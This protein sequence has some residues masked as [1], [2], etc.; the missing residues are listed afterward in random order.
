MKR[1]LQFLFLILLL[2]FTFLAKAEE[3]YTFDPMHSYVLYHINHF[4]F[5]NP[6]GKWMFNGTVSLDKNKPQNSKVNIV[7]KTADIVTGIP[8]L[9]DHLKKPLFFDVGKF[10]TATFV[11]N[12]VTATG[13]ETAKVQGILTLHGVSKPVT[14]NVKL[15]KAGENPVNNK[16]GVGFTASTKLKR[17]DFGI[18]AF[19][20]GLGDDV[21]IDIEAEAYK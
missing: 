2:P 21:K 14:L 8:E 11:S 4:G 12:K 7:I 18:D 6:S 17:S 16:I 19:S 3:T 15:N 1:S 13:R 5:S 10:P 9:D 20:P